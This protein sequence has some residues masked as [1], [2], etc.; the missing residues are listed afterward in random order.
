MTFS[1]EQA[2]VI[3]GTSRRDGNTRVAVERVVS[4]RGVE[5]VD[6]SQLELSAYD[7][8]HGNAEDG[9]IPLVESI[10][11]K[12]LWILATPV[13]WYSMSAQLKVFVDRLTDLITIR[14]DL[15][16]LLR[17]KSL[18]VV[19]SGTDRELPPGFE[20]PFRLTCEY[21]GM[22]YIGASY[23]QFEKNDE[24]V[25]NLRAAASEATWIS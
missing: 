9:F 7:Y 13:Y 14:K 10:A 15:G 6:L 25:P 16:R 20:A 3:L 17:G 22:C 5:I 1:P 2:V 12:P 23:W 18:A 24:L 21:L 8:D 11:E 4:G 19:A